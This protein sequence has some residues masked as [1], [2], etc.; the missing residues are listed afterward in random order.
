MYADQHLIVQFLSANKYKPKDT[1][2]AMA[3]HAEFKK[4]YLPTLRLE[5]VLNIL[6]SHRSCLEN[7]LLLPLRKRPL[8][9]AHLGL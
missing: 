8:L 5:N 3:E 4:A 1:L 9:Q 2:K 7:G 6:V